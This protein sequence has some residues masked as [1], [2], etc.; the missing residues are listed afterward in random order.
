MALVSERTSLVEIEVPMVG[1]VVGRGQAGAGLVVGAGG[2]RLRKRLRGRWG[3]LGTSSQD[4]LELLGAEM[5][6]V[7]VGF[8]FGFYFG[9]WLL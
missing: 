8:F 6:G 4:I 9:S 7:H 3:I 1:A 5:V 2:G